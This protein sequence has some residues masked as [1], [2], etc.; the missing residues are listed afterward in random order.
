MEINS[1]QELLERLEEI[2][3][4]QVQSIWYRG[5]GSKDWSLTPYYLRLDG[6]QSES[7][8]LKRFKQSAA[9]LIETSP[10]ESFD[11]LFLMQHYGVPTRLLDWSESP[12]VALYFA[13]E[14]IE[15]HGEEDGALWLLYPSE[16]NKHARINNKEEEGFIPSF[17][18]EEL[19]SY[20]VESLKSNSRIQL[21]PVATIAT[22]NNAR[23]QAQLGVF[24]IHHHENIPIEEVGDR[25]HTLKFVIPANSKERIK[26]QLALLGYTKFQLFP[27]LSS[28]GDIIKEG[29]K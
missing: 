3:K 28:I 11:W 8:L 22:R 10:K 18:D 25:S 29:I 16:L 24:T 20:S 7:T 2:Q 13:V 9:M 23:I 27:E 1:V 12:L 6:R 19:E 4:D 14:N 5:Q 21:F 26:N 15:K 17:D